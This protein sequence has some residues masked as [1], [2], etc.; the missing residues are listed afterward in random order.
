MRVSGGLRHLMKRDKNRCHLCGLKVSR[1][2]ASRDHVKPRS[3]G[4]QSCKSNL[5]LAHKDC[6]LLRDTTPV[7]TRITQRGWRWLKEE[8]S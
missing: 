8:R 5:A 1:E 6:N 2:E 7:D 3:Q 4:G